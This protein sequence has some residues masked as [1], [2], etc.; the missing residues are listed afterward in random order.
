[1]TENNEGLTMKYFVL[2]PNKKDAYG[3]ASRH[4][5]LMYASHIQHENPKLAEDL[6]EWIYSIDQRPTI[7]DEREKGGVSEDLIEHFDYL[8]KNRVRCNEDVYK[9]LF[10]EKI[11]ALILSGGE[12]EQP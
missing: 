4:A 10:C 8:R 3:L 5:I 11:R 9:C 2:N 12:K 7:L 1:M 6:R